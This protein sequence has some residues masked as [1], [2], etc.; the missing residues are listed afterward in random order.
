MVVP[1]G[2]QM[3]VTV[4]IKVIAHTNLFCVGNYLKM[5]RMDGTV[6]TY[7]EATERIGSD[8]QIRQALKSGVLH[9]VA[10]GVYST[11]KHADP[12][13]IACTK[14]PD[15]IITMDSA[16][17]IL[18]FTDTVPEEVHLA[19]RRNTTRIRD[20]GI[21]QYFLETDIFSQGAKTMSHAGGTIRIYDAERMLVEL[22]RNSASMPLDYYKEVINN[23]RRRSETLDIRSVEDYMDMFKR[24]DAMFD[25]LQKEVL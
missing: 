25:I 2:I 9:K 4:A 10:R 21:K 13:L 5:K 11:T 8:Y 23:Y 1:G 7:K 16:F 20:V 3:D 6:M 17:Y 12:Y 19:T 15:A 22:M 24:N 14:Y 18:G